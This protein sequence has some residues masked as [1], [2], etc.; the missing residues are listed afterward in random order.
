MHPHSSA[1]KKNTSHGNEVLPRDTSHLIQRPYYQRESLCQD[2]ASNRTTRSPDFVKRRKLQQ[3]GHASLLSGLA[4]TILQDTVKGGRSSLVGALSPVNHR[5]LHQGYKGGRRQGRQRKR[6]KDNIK[7]WTV[8]EFCKS[9]R[10][11][12]SREKRRKLVAIIICGAQT[13]LAV[14]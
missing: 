8:L 5:G 14:S 10:A 12:R 11:V 7:E 1:P 3:Y 6:W 9:K 13:T 2:P 4:K